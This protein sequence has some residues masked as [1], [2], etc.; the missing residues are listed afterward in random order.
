MDR[1]HFI[2]AGIAFTALMAMHQQAQIMS[3][4]VPGKT[5]N[6]NKKARFSKIILFTP[7]FEEQYLFYSNTL[8]FTTIKLNDSSFVVK[9][10]E[11]D[12]IFTKTIDNK[13][14]IYHYAINIP[15]NKFLQ[16]KEWLKAKTKLL[17]DSLSGKDEIF[18]E[19]W[20]AHAVYFKDPDGNIGELISRHT[21]NNKR[22]GDFTLD[23]LLCVSEI[24][25][26][27]DNPSQV[28]SD[29][30]LAFGLQRY[31]DSNMFVGD[32]YGLFIVA[33][34]GR[35][36]IPERIEKATSCRTNIY[37]TDKQLVKFNIPKYPFEIYGKA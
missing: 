30:A 15:T 29:L 35:L 6:N 21:L 9:I 12:L 23:D 4:P 8:K 34:P 36:W 31:Q 27:F 28:V 16:G 22:G 20:N 37:I 5:L 19:A 25:I 32:E 11:S 7:N 13:N 17:V 3:M 26:P 33:P 14:C 2:A 10:G 1:R 24:S 18:F